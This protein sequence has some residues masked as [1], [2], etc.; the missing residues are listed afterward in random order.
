MKNTHISF[1]KF[2]LPLVVVTLAYTIYSLDRNRLSES[3]DK[4]CEFFEEEVGSIVNNNGLKF[5]G[6]F[7]YREKYYQKFAILYSNEYGLG[8]DIACHYER[9]SH[10][11]TA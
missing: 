6:S 4:M 11:V 2:I 10:K 7:H 9:D 3:A 5:N 1:R 8:K